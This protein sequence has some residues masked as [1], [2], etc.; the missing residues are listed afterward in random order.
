V[1]AGACGCAWAT[2]VG[3]T[4]K[5]E[6]AMIQVTVVAAARQ[7][8]RLWRGMVPPEKLGCF[9]RLVRLLRNI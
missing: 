2:A 9:A 4:I 1:C 3:A 6:I 7:R 5:E 8:K